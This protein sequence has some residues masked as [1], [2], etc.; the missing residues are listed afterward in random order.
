MPPALANRPGLLKHQEI[1][2]EAFL[3][4]SSGRQNTDHVINPITFTDV[5]LYCDCIYVFDGYERLRYWAM[6]NSCDTSF[7]EAML[8]KRASKVTN[9]PKQK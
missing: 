2:H 8:Q 7:I 6:I 1:Y 3:L 9:K 4:L 5:M